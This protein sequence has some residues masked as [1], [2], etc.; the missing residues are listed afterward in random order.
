[1]PVISTRT[2]KKLRKNRGIPDNIKSKESSSSTIKYTSDT[3]EFETD[4][5]CAIIDLRLSGV[6]SLKV[7]K[8]K[9]VIAV[10][11]KRNNRIMFITMNPSANC[12]FTASYQGRLHVDS[13]KITNIS[14]ANYNTNTANSHDALITAHS[15]EGTWNDKS[16]GLAWTSSTNWDEFTPKRIYNGGITKRKITITSMS[17]DVAKNLSKA[18]HIEYSN[19]F[20]TKKELD[21]KKNHLLPKSYK[22]GIDH[23]KSQ[24]K[25]LC[26]DCK[27]FN[28]NDKYCNL[29]SSPVN[30]EYYCN[31]YYT[32]DNLNIEGPSSDEMK[33]FLSSYKDKIKSHCP[34]GYIQQPDGSCLRIEDK[35]DKREY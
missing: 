18:P 10:S 13:C 11:S 35:D 5:W 1:M 27:H 19:N 28:I 16:E 12:N 30:E 34:D 32:R 8:P 9:D 31:K 20:L 22:Q 25:L 26:R 7:F 2:R 14:G 24:G 3:L 17:N 29:W 23:I 21:I 6:F 15:R 4:G 33:N